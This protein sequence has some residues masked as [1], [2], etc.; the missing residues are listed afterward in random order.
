MS[1]LENIISGTDHFNN[2]LLLAFFSID[3]FY[4]MLVEH[5]LVDN[6]V[7]KFIYQNSN[8]YLFTRTFIKDLA[9]IMPLTVLVF[10]DTSKRT[11]LILDRAHCHYDKNRLHDPTN[12]ESG[13]N[14]MTAINY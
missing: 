11:P 13:Y 8:V 3:I 14:E 4:C 6:V 7:T 12:I 5:P 10:I 1:H 2:K 9:V